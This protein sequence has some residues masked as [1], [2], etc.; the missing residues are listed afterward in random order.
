MKEVNRGIKEE[1]WFVVRNAHMPSVLVE[2]GFIT[3][4]QDAGL[5]NDKT[6]LRKTALGIYNGLGAFITHFEQSRGFTGTR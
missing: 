1:E 2:L 3:N 6:Y 5:L 4:L